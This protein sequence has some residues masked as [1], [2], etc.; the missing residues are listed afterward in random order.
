MPSLEAHYHPF[1]FGAM[2]LSALAELGL[3][4]FLI[5]AG[6]ENG[7]WPRPR[8]HSL[9]IMFCFN[10]AWTTLFSTTYLLWYMDGTSHFLANV[11]SSVI[12]LV[13]TSALWGSA[14]G[15]MHNTRTG[16]DC[17]RRATISRCRQSLT[18][19]ALGWTEL[20]L[21]ALVTLTTCVWAYSS[22]LTRCRLASDSAS[23]SERLV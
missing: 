5:S 23:T 13:L 9:L 8:Y 14:A 22:R 16:G 18:V 6:N 19:E 11:A 2:V 4:S 12:W 20:G 21:C 17:A 15:I 1:L 10:A 3:T 7:T